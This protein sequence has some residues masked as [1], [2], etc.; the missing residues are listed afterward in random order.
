MSTCRPAV[1]PT[2]PS[3]QR[4]CGD[5]QY[6]P[7]RTK[8]CRRAPAPASTALPAVPAT[9]HWHTG[10]VPSRGASR[11]PSPD[12]GA[13]SNG[14]GRRGDRPALGAV[15]TAGRR[16]HSVLRTRL[17]PRGRRAP[18]YGVPA[19]FVHR[20]EERCRR[21]QLA[22]ASVTAHH[23]P[24]PRHSHNAGTKRRA[25]TDGTSR[26]QGER[27]APC[28]L[29]AHNSPTGAQRVRPTRP[30]PRRRAR[31]VPGCGAAHSPVASN[32]RR[33]RNAV[34]PGLAACE[35]IPGNHA[36]A[37]PAAPRAAAGNAML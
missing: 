34:A 2:V 36:R 20:G 8:Q 35:T 28:C 4:R 11:L 9:H 23:G 19:R 33:Q 10:H 12:R 25:A 5:S 22:P 32:A 37:K 27:H 7:V 26:P 1:A 17:Y 14:A 21:P 30:A 6:P 13:F 3:Q 18:I 15:P 29:H 16:A 24:P 31:V